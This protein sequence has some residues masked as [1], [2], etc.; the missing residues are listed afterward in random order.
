MDTSNSDSS[1]SQKPPEVANLLDA[2]PAVTSRGVFMLSVE[3]KSN[4]V[5]HGMYWGMR[6][7]IWQALCS[8]PDPK[9]NYLLFCL[10]DPQELPQSI[11]DFYALHDHQSTAEGI[12]RLFKKLDKE[13][14]DPNECL[15]PSDY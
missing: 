1:E 12:K 8:P 4:P 2:F 14:G 11:V 10:F 13:I 7:V 15:D 3:N 5:W 9:Y 6:L